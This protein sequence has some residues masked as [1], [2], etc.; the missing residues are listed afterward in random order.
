MVISRLKILVHL[1]NEIYE[2]FFAKS[3]VNWGIPAEQEF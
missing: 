3:L 1:L 2:L